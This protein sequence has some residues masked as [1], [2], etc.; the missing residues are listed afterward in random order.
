MLLGVFHHCAI[1]LDMIHILGFALIVSAEVCNL[2]LS[3][4]STLP[5]SVEMVD[6]VGSCKK[7]NIEPVYRLY[8]RCLDSN[9]DWTWQPVPTYHRLSELN[10]DSCKIMT[11]KEAGEVDDRFTCFNCTKLLSREDL[12]THLYV[13]QGCQK[14]WE[15]SQ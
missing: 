13:C 14:K 10:L 7:D 9:G 11:E 1:I 12:R 8:W 4:N 3:N 2:S 5:Q 6:A 15:G